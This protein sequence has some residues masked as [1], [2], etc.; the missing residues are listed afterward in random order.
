VIGHFHSAGVP[1]RHEL[2]Q[3]EIDYPFLTRQIESMGYQGIFG[4][5]YQ[6]STDHEESVRKTVA[7][8]RR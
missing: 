6:P 8:L 7:Y 5:E 4:L 2:Y 1:G 3:G